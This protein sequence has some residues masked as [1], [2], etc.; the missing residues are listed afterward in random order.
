MILLAVAW[1]YE[2]GRA[3]GQKWKSSSTPNELYV[4]ERYFRTSD[5]PNG[6]SNEKI[7]T[8]V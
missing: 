6:D 2:E 1:F 7:F 8:K 3:I 4:I 5:T